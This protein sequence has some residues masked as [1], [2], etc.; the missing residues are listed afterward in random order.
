MAPPKVTF[1]L[2]TLNAAQ[3]LPRCLASIRRQDYPAEACEIVVADGGSTDRTRA[4]AAEYG[5]VVLDNPQRRAEPGK[6][7]AF[8]RATGEY[9]VFLD[10]DNEIAGTD[11]LRRA[12]Q[13]LTARPEA[14]GFES[15]YLKKPGD[16]RLNH[17][18]TALLQC[19]SD[20]IVRTLSRMPRLVEEDAQGVQV[21]ALPA[22]G[23]Y[24]TG[25]NGFIFRRA[26]LEALPAGTSFHEA[27]FFP[28]LIRG[29]RR[30]LLK[31]RGCGIYHF[32]VTN[33]SDYLAKRRYTMVNYLLRKEE[34]T[35]TWDAGGGRLRRAATVLYHATL[36]GPLMEGLARAIAAGDPTWLLHP[37]ASALSVLGNALG[38]LDYRRAGSSE[39]GI[40]ASVRLH[41]HASP[42]PA[43]KPDR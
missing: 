36:V 25:A 38:Y 37:L 30:T 3:I 12:M 18:V 9:L 34:H 29:G 39:E 23:A 35:G 22:D 1:I 13:A 42:P 14:L 8:A 32:Y 15:Y 26:Y 19:S 33:W 27:T 24:P 5:A 4:I 41:R 16:A 2:P 7:L 43:P 20:P 10:A 11:W 21:F 28:D 31:I 40:K 17:Y 6:Q